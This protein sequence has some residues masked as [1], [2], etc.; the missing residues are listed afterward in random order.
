MSFQRNLR[1]FSKKLKKRENWKSSMDPSQKEE[2]PE[3]EEE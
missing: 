1:T 2:K 3:E